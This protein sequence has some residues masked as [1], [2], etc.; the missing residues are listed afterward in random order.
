[1]SIYGPVRCEVLQGGVGVAGLGFQLCGRHSHPLVPRPWLQQPGQG[2][3]P[4][5]CPT[6]ASLPLTPSVVSTTLQKRLG[7]AVD[8]IMVPKM[9]SAMR[10]DPVEVLSSGQKGLS[11]SDSVTDLEGKGRGPCPKEASLNVEGGGQERQWGVT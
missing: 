7:P 6:M 9:A 11:S 5:P 2:V 4:S 1:M 10:W 3:L 8:K